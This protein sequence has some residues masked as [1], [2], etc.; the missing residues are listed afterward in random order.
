MYIGIYRKAA[1]IFFFFLGSTLL[2]FFLYTRPPRPYQFSR[3]RGEKQNKT[4]FDPA[5]HAY[6]S[7]DTCNELRTIQLY[8]YTVEFACSDGVLLRVQRFSAN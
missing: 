8:V 4:N 7:N 2:C 1:M 5:T 3:R 6:T